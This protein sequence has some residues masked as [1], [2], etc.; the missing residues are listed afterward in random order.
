MKQNFGLLQAGILLALVLLLFLPTFLIGMLDLETASRSFA[1]GDYAR[2]A[3]AFA[4]AAPRLPW[5]KHLWGQAAQTA[6]L[7]GETE[8]A[9]LWFAEGEAR[10]ALTLADWIAYGDAFQSAGDTDSAIWA[11]KQSI[12]HFG[13]NAEAEKRLA[14]AYRSKGE[15]ELALSC[16]QKALELAPEDAEAHFEQGLLLAALRP[17]SA[18]PDLMKA[19]ALDPS[20]DPPVQVLRTELNRAS[21]TI[22]E[23]AYQFLVAGRAL[24]A[25]GQ[26]DLAAEAFRRAIETKAD[27]AEAWAWLGEA[28]QH[29]GQDGRLE[30]DRA[31]SLNQTSASIWAFD[32]LYW[33]RQKQPE[34]A[35]EAC[36]KSVA[37]EPENPA[38]QV[39][40]G[41]AAAAAGEF[42]Q[43]IAAYQRATELDPEHLPAWRGLAIVSLESG[44]DISGLGRVAARELLRLAPDDW[45]SHDL[46]GQ[47]ALALR[48]P[49]EAEEQLLK[50]IELAPENPAPHLH[51]ALVYLEFGKISAAYDKL[52]DTI[53]LDPQGSYG[54][55]A[56]RLVEQYFP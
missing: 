1:A 26:W 14:Q 3:Q 8:Q 11:W 54:W 13:I 53:Q 52:L 47:M 56:K 24:A 55:Q 10:R 31:L 30:L 36:Q 16:L 9:L 20:F 33:L 21:L 27:Y 50:A 45:L 5:Q 22:G 32:G 41:D 12:L 51:L 48:A 39:A 17:A 4:H 25:L 19:A 18:L 28:R 23:P 44:A 42:S 29:T 49:Q 35:L 6:F 38:W 46:A 40:L 37:L 7:A 34:K 2:A 43:A 15:Y